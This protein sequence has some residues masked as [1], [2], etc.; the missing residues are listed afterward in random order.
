VTLVDTGTG[1]LFSLREAF[2]RTETEVDIVRDAAGIREAECLILPG[3]ASFPRMSRGIGPFREELLASVDR[4]VPLLGICAGMQILF[5]S[6]EEGPGNGLGLFP[7]R[8]ET[9]R[10]PVV[11]HMGWSPIRRKDDPWFAGLPPEPAVY[12]AH[13]FA[14]RA[15]T[16]GVVATAEHDAPFAAAIRRDALFGVQ[17]HPEKSGRTGIAILQGFLREAGVIPST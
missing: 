2:R 14:A 7:G 9:L 3:V 10:A 17:F 4:G 16:P 12:F 1:N 13:S 11:P 8:V 6:S 5:E 15:D